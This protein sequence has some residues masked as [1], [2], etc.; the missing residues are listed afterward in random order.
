MKRKEAR[1]YQ[2][3]IISQVI[4]NTKSTLIQIPTGAGKTFIAYE[5]AKELIVKFN[6][7]VLF[8]APRENLMNQTAEEFKFSRPHII[9]SSNKD[10]K[11]ITTY[12]FKTYPLL[13]STLQT[14][15]RRN[16]VNPDVIIIDET[17]FGFDGKMINDLIQSNKNSRII[18]LSATPYDKYGHQLIGFELVLDKYDMK[19]MIDNGY[20][21]PLKSYKRKKINLNKVKIT[22]NGDYDETQLEKVVCNNHTIMEIVETTKDKIN[23]SLKTII[24]A[25][26][27]KHADLLAEAYKNI[28]F[29]VKS[30]HSKSEELDSQIIHD[31]KK[32]YIK[33]LVSVSKLTTGFDVPETDCAVIARPTKSQNLYKQMVGRIL[34]LSPSTN[35][36]H[37]VLLDCGNVIDNLGDP[38]APIKI[39]KLKENPHKLKCNQCQSEKLKLKKIDKK[40][41]WE[42]QECGYQKKIN[43][44]V[45]KCKY[46][47]QYSN[48]QSQFIFT[49]NKILLD[50]NFCRQTTVISEY[51][52]K[53]ELVC[54]NKSYSADFEKLINEMSDEEYDKEIFIQ[55]TKILKKYFNTDIL[56]NNKIKKKIL[57]LKKL[58]KEKKYLLSCEYGHD[59]M[60]EFVKNDNINLFNEIDILFY[61]HSLTEAELFHTIEFDNLDDVIDKKYFQNNLSLYYLTNQLLM[62]DSYLKQTINNEKIFYLFILKLTKKILQHTGHT[63]EIEELIQ[64]L[65]PKKI[66][67]S[68]VKENKIQSAH[69]FIQNLQFTNQYFDNFNQNITNYK[70][71]LSN[72]QLFQY[73]KIGG[74]IQNDRIHT[75]ICN[76]NFNNTNKDIIKNIFTIKKRSD[77]FHS[78]LLLNP[79]IALKNKLKFILDES[80]VN[81][82]GILKFLLYLE[83][84]KS[85][86]EDIEKIIHTF[87]NIS[88]TLPYTPNIKNILE[89]NEIILA[90]NFKLKTLLKKHK[91]NINE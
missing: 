18:G 2:K 43:E 73:I 59:S 90:L 75:T 52:G 29:S 79:T 20:L 58:K 77:K 68:S 40:S 4:N 57:A 27:I 49:T 6:Q 72:D 22:K 24:F 85:E 65:K 8:V 80:K 78:L 31:F 41:F 45:Y 53:E 64:E 61:L 70:Y 26:T 46:C 12:D 60:L 36:T 56:H 81:T 3:D 89:S 86:I 10:D 69:T 62:N 87:D 39:V 11:N 17:H 66:Q 28:G 1:N 71:K 14:A 35:K 23:E 7:Q 33:I 15:Y 16:N 44:G 63:A 21:V 38:L 47:N 42:C 54:V 48:N 84:N 30:L 19:Y 82:K 76:L 91:A 67:N 34:R 25:V 37:A 50:C 9:H 51:S 83:I 88:D 74:N 13:I 32:G 55:Y 5:I